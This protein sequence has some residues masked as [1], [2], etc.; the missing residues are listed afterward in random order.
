M[1]PIAYAPLAVA[2]LALAACGKPEGAASNG[3]GGAT[4]VAGAPAPAGKSWADVV[5]A[6]PEGGFRMGNPDASIKIIEFGS[7]TCPHC[8]DF[9]EAAHEPLERDFVNSGKV[10]FEYRNFVRDP[11]DMVVALV[12]RCGG[13][14][15]FFPLNLQFFL[16]Q[17]DMIKQIQAGG[18]GAYQAALSAGPSERFIKLAQLAGLIEY[19]KQR[20]LPEDKVRACL[21]DPKA[22]EA[23]AAGVE[24]DSKQYEISGTPTIIM[25]GKRLDNVA[26]WDS[27][28]KHLKDA[29]A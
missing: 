6:T 29:G 25:N 16:N 13:P 27:L 22:P 20:G 17:E 14:E 5:E 3:T 12:A 26:T 1:K 2:L 9:T 24:R 15:A 19:A 7:Y 23:L 10:S 21:A 8:R 4:A 11:L 18:E 28:A